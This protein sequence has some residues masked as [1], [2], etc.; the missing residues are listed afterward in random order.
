L[1]YPE[2]NFGFSFELEKVESF[3]GFKDPREDDKYNFN[4]AQM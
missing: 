1:E 3:D 2:A 4:I